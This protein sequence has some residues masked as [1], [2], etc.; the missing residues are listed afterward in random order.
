MLQVICVNIGPKFDP[1]YVYRMQ[2]AVSLN[3]DVPHDFAVITD[4]PELYRCRTLEPMDNLKGYWQKITLFAPERWRQYAGDRVLYLDL[5]TVVMG[6]ITELATYPAK[7]LTLKDRLLPMV[8]SSIMCWDFPEFKHI[9]NNWKGD[10][11]SW[12]RGDQEWINSQVWPEFINEAFG[13]AEYPDFKEDLRHQRPSGNER[14]VWFHGIPMPHE[15]DW[16]QET[17]RLQK[18]E[19][20]QR[21]GK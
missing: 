7:F 21:T 16:V 5:D 10:T 9:Y 19:Y 8:N 3:L 11:A 1:E 15:L 4:M 6:N 12:P 17:W 20:Q 18:I 14:I 2:R 13:T